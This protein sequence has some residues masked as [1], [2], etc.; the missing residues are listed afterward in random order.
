MFADYFYVS[1]EMLPQIMP[2]K[3]RLTHRPIRIW[4]L[5]SYKTYLDTKPVLY[6]DRFRI[7]YRSY[8]LDL[9]QNGSIQNLHSIKY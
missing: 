3:L 2:S 4:R 1:V 7:F 9:S 5:F 8:K 6:Q